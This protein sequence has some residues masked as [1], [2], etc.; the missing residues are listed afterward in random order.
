MWL[1]QV[2]VVCGLGYKSSRSPTAVQCGWWPW[3]G[4]TLAVGGEQELVLL[5]GGCT[6]TQ[7]ETATASRCCPS[8]KPVLRGYPYLV[9]Y[10]QAEIASHLC[11]MMQWSKSYKVIC[12]ENMDAV[13]ELSVNTSA[14]A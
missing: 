10:L 3:L 5:G 4:E 13:T 7:L 8:C 2:P 9:I 11:T 1:S 6:G 14:Q 12:F